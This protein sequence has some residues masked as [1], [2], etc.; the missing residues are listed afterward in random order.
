MMYKSNGKFKATKK[1]KPTT[2]KKPTKQ[3]MAVKATNRRRKRR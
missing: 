3:L 2:K 1:S